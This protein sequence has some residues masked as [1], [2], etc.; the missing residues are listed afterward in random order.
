MKLKTE[1]KPEQKLSLIECDGCFI[2]FQPERMWEKFC[3]SCSYKR[4]ELKFSN[5]SSNLHWLVIIVA[6][7]CIAMF[8]GILYSAIQHWHVELLK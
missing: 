7:F 8:G 5:P 4:G 3:P 2:H 1:P 6:V